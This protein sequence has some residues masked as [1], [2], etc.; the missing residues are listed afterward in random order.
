MRTHVCGKDV[1][2]LAGDDGHSAG[3]EP[4]GSMDDGLM[5]ELMDEPFQAMVQA[6]NNAENFQLDK[7]YN[8]TG[9]AEA[10]CEKGRIS[11]A[12]E[13]TTVCKLDFMLQWNGRWSTR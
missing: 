12:T 5:D 1:D 4:L 9:Q 8:K 6:F 3:D 10:A 13:S 11:K 7:N 2:V